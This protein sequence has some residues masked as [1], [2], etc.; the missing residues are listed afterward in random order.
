MNV[1]N[2]KIE[3]PLELLEDVL[4]V[5]NSDT[6][7]S[8]VEPPYRIEKFRGD[9]FSAGFSIVTLNGFHSDL[10]LQDDESSLVMLRRSVMDKVDGMFMMISGSGASHLEKDLS[11]VR[12]KLQVSNEVSSRISII[13]KKLEQIE[14]SVGGAL[15]GVYFERCIQITLRA[16]FESIVKIR[17]LTSGTEFVPLEAVLHAYRQGLLPYGWNADTDR[18]LCV[19]P[20]YS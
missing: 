13:A 11:T 15:T 3:C 5:F 18:V 9:G 19:N 12:N 20:E 8:G 7:L 1:L 2:R 16:H 4:Q 14:N 6:L 10:D 17:M